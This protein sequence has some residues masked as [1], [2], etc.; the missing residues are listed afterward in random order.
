MPPHRV[1]HLVDVARD[2][3]VAHAEEA[4]PELG[5]PVQDL[6]LP[7]DA[8]R[9]DDV[10]GAQPIGRDDEQGVAQVEDVAHLAVR[11]VCEPGQL[12]PGEDRLAH[13]CP[14][15]GTTSDSWPGSFV[16]TA[17][18]AATRPRPSLPP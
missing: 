15:S 8:V 12:A 13:I 9:H 17:M 11:D 18:R 14:S 4:E 7:R 10:E 6:P 5:E 1:R 16:R 3:V 2:H